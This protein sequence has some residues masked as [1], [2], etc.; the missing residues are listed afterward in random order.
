M[1]NLLWIDDNASRESMAKELAEK[2]RLRC[3]FRKPGEWENVA[4]ESEDA[5]L[6]VIDH[7]L[8]MDDRKDF[9][10]KHTGAACCSELR[11]DWQDVPVICISSATSS[12]I[13]HSIRNEY[14]YFI[15]ETEFDTKF[16]F[17]ESTVEGFRQLRS[18]AKENIDSAQLRSRLIAL[19]Q[20]PDSEED[21]LRMIMPKCMISKETYNPHNVY[22]WLI[23]KF[24]A[25]D[26]LLISEYSLSGAIGLKIEA[27]HRILRNHLDACRYKGIFCGCGNVLYWKT[28]VNKLL[29]EI[30]G[31][32]GSIPLSHYCE[33]LSGSTQDDYALCYRCNKPYTE[34]VAMEDATDSAKSYPAHYDCCDEI[35]EGQSLFFDVDYIIKE[36]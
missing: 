30:V 10:P 11:L 16:G 23:S 34:V 5:D 18:V 20:V 19:L 35:L 14:D 17:I 21:S 4:R 3:V 32:D 33:H 9:L 6:I 13:N 7:Y 8:R 29:H 2:L 31:N 26:G 1:G 12:Q 36:S 27:F 24:L 25:K 15:T 22:R 28:N